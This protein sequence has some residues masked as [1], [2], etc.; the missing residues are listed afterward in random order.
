M[1]G[2]NPKRMYVLE[3]TRPFAQAHGMRP[4][5]TLAFYAAPDRRLVGC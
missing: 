3:A 1:N 4:G 2:S 5:S